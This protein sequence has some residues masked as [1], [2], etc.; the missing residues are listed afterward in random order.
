MVDPN[1]DEF[2]R[3]AEEVYATRL[4]AVLEPEQ[5]D[6]FVAIEPESG[7]YYLGSTLRGCEKM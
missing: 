4:K 5:I 6:Q 2:V 7:E 3:K 1:V